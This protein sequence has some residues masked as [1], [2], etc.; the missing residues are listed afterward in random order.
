MSSN[1]A[2]KRRTTGK[3]VKLSPSKHRKL[4][5]YVFNRDEFCVF[6]GSP[7][8]LTPAHVINRSQG[9]SDS[10]KNIVTACISCHAVYDAYQIDLPES[11]LLML[12]NEPD[13]L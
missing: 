9:G 6:C 3:R 2:I 10:P 8:N 13:G 11:V 1:R 7:N 4:C 5:E 12:E